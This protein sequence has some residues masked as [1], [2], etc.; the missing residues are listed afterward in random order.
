MNRSPPRS[1]RNCRPCTS[2]LIRWPPP[3]RRLSWMPPPPGPWRDSSTGGQG[4]GRGGFTLVEMLVVMVLMGL[5][6]GSAFSLLAS[7][8]GSVTRGME[9]WDRLEAVRT[10]WVSVERDLRPGLA[11]RD[12]WVTPGGVLQLR[13]FRG[14]AR[15]CGPAGEPGLFP[16]VWRGDRLPVPQRDSVLVLG[17]DGGW[18]GG[19]LTRWTEAQVGCDPAPGEREG[20]VSW[21]GAGGEPPVLIRLFERGAY[22]FHQGAFRYERGNAGR[23]PLTPELFGPGSR[24]QAEKFGVSVEWTYPEG[25]G[26]LEATAVDPL[27]FRVGHEEP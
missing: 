27:T 22:S 21:S 19:S 9:R 24:F 1:R 16:A 5:L 25:P 2:R 13:A 10:V 17:E 4:E 12:W 20:W 14:F 11:D 6:L 8:S 26:T 23:Q 18:R 7:V 15:I 3:V